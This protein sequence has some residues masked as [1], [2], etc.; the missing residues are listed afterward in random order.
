M[1]PLL[2]APH[3]SAM[4]KHFNTFALEEPSSLSVFLLVPRSS[5]TVVRSITVKGSYVGNREDA[6]QALDIA[7]RGRV[8]TT[9]RVEPLGALPAVFKEMKEGKLAGR[10][11]LD[12]VGLICYRE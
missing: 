4:I 12:L 1:Q 2:Q 3:L 10:V 9:Y 11:V 7:A 6:R 5:W 8:K